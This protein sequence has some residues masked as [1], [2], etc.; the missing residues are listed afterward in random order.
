MFV[1]LL[2]SDITDTNGVDR[3]PCRTDILF[4]SIIMLIALTVVPKQ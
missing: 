4:C 1:A 2:K 3:E